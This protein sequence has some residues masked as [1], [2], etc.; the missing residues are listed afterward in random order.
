MITVNNLPALTY[1]VAVCGGSGLDEAAGPACLKFTVETVLANRLASPSKE[2]T[3]LS[4]SLDRE[5]RS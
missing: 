5:M 3:L 2:L 1:D 4:A